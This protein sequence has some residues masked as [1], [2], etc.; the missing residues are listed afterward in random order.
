[1]GFFVFFFVFFRYTQNMKTYFT[2]GLSED[3]C[4]LETLEDLL[5][6]LALL[7]LLGWEVL[8]LTKL[9][10][11]GLSASLTFPGLFVAESSLP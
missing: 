8:G 11:L 7:L 6:G 5:R 1:M 10:S 9:L 4:W 2:L 3:F